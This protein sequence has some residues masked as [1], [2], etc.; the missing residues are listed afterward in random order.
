MKVAE[1][2]DNNNFYLLLE[3]NHKEIL[4]F[5]MEELRRKT[6]TTFV[7]K[8]SCVILLL[9]YAVALYFYISSGAIG[10][11]ESIAFWC[12]GVFLG[13]TAIIPFHEWLHGIAYKLV[14]APKVSYRGS[15]KQM[16]FY[17]AADQF[18]IGMNSFRFVA[19]TPFV[20]I[21][22]LLIAGYFHSG[23]ALKFG[24]L[25]FLISH[26]I[27]C[28]GDFG[29]LS[30]IETQHDKTLYTYDDMENEVSYVYAVKEPPPEA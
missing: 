12:I 1:L 10:F 4:P 13:T 20:V 25:G 16:M 8:G 29:L 7:F 22:A 11:A 21:S 14:G 5:I 18:V 6:I 2:K 30:Y 9:L 3:L 24:I 26:T 27:A 23:Y 19:L 17:A 15:F 28:A